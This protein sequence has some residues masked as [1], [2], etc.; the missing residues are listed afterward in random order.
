MKFLFIFILFSIIITNSVFALDLGDGSDGACVSATFTTVK[1][2]YQCTTLTISSPLNIFSGIGGPALI[3]RVQQAVT[4]TSAG[5]IN[6][7]GATGSDGNTGVVTG[8][9]AGA[10][11]A[12][13]SAGG[14]PTLLDGENGNG[15]G[16]GVGGKRPPGVNIPIIG[17]GGGG[18]SYNTI[19]IIS[20]T[21]GQDGGGIITGT[22]GANGVSAYGLEENFENNFYGGSGGAAGGAGVDGGTIVWYGSSGGGGGGAL[23]IVAGG[24]ISIAGTIVSNGGNGGGTNVVIYPG[25]GGAGSGG[26]IWLQSLGNISVSSTGSLT[27]LGGTGVTNGVGNS[28]GAGGLGRIRLDDQDGIMSNSGTITPNAYKTII[29]TTTPVRQY[30]S[31]VA[32]GRVSLEN[33]RPVNNLINLLLGMMIA[34]GIYLAISKRAKV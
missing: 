7:S 34:A 21:E 27:A 33:E 28:G 20:A 5:T 25:G 29:Q 13:G 19:S 14:A 17:G 4:V 3:I 24:N 15:L 12:G 26:A 30:S 8:G 9:L 6:L 22:L 23:H 32:C 10:G 16:A 11:G 2:N 18:G 1:K 31:A